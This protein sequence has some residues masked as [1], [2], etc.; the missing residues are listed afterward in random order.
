MQKNQ[1]IL[2]RCFAMSAIERHE[3]PGNGRGT[4]VTMWLLYDDDPSMWAPLGCE[5]SC[6]VDE[7]VPVSC[8]D[9]AG[10]KGCL[11]KLLFVRPIFTSIFMHAHDIQAETTTDPGDVSSEVFINQKQHLV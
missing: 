3:R 8:N 6:E 10:F 11:D 7:V 9:A 4:H 2:G 5:L 1:Q